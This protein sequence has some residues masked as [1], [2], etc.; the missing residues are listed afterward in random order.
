MKILISEKQ[1]NLILES[2]NKKE[3]FL[4]G[5]CNNSTWRDD[6]IPK[7]KINFFNPVVEEWTEKDA[8]REIEKRKTCDYLLYVITPKMTGVLSIAEITED[9]IRQPDKTLFCFLKKDDKKEFDKDQI[10]SLEA[11]KK[12]VKE[13]GAKVFNNLDE[14]AKYLNK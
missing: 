13:N 3:V 11:V 8:K 12:M 9:S 10:K 1:Y 6:L 14:I 4:G 7:L 5:T 2:K